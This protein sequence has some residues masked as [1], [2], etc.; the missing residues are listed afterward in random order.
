MR[1]STCGGTSGE[2]SFCIYCGARLAEPS[3]PIRPDDAKSLSRDLLPIINDRDR[4]DTYISP[5]WAIAIF[6]AVMIIGFALV[7]VVFIEVLDTF[8]AEDYDPDNPFS[9]Y[10]LYLNE[11]FIILI[12][13]NTAMYLVLA[14]LAHNLVRRNNEHF[15]RERRFR[16]AVGAFA[17]RTGRGTS[18]FYTPDG[19]EPAKRSPI[20]WALVVAIPG[21]MSVAYVAVM[22]VDSGSD[23]TYTTIMAM[24]AVLQIGLGLLLLVGQ[25]YLFYFL[26]K[27]MANHHGRWVW[28]ARGTKVFLGSMGYTAGWLSEPQP[29]PDR[30]VAV[31]I[32]VS[33]FTGG[34]FFFY[35]W[36]AIIKDG[37][38]HFEHHR[39]FEN[40]LL[41]LLTG[42][43]APAAPDRSITWA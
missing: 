25:F 5:L 28:F 17:S 16:E 3:V 6:V 21:I 40:G 15:A 37:N 34:L 41:E 22:A 4:T 38:A 24:M 30:S 18:Q 27:D 19:A 42:R 36:Y 11:A 31:Y 8:A 35:W 13:M 26:T 33:I 29:L 32:V 14:R 39:Q 9:A 23:D 2:G 12:A 1:C 43:A 10:D 20:M 7:A